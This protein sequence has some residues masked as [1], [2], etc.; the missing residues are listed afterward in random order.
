[1]VLLTRPPTPHFVN[2]CSTPFSHV[3]LCRMTFAIFLYIWPLIQNT[4]YQRRQKR[5][6]ITILTITCTCSYAQTHMCKQ[7]TLAERKKIYRQNWVLI[8]RFKRVISYLFSTDDTSD[9]SLLFSLF[10]TVVS[11]EPHHIRREKEKLNCRRNEH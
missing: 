9:N 3:I 5:S 2:F 7:A 10:F 4:L 8:N 1:M 11:S 6:E